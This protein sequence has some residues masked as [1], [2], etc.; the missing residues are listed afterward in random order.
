MSS[1]LY[2]NLD[3]QVT[4]HH[5]TKEAPMPLE[6]ADKVEELRQLWIHDDVADLG[7][8]DSGRM[9][10]VKCKNCTHEYWCDLGD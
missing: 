5:C 1:K 7:E 6:I 10:H 8:S 9:I 2:P 4:V 3:P